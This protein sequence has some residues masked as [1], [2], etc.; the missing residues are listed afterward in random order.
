[1][2]CNCP[3]TYSDGILYRDADHNSND[4]LDGYASFH[5]NNDCHPSHN[6]NDDDYPEPNGNH[7]RH[8]TPISNQ[9]G[10]PDPVTLFFVRTLLIIH[11]PSCQPFTG[12][13]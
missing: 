1:M 13:L 2:G 6:V 10:D 12:G 8:P 7:V 9:D 4:N 11:Y 5:S 3:P